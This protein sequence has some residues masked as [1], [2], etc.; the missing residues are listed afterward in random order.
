[1]VSG[2][3]FDAGEKDTPVAGAMMSLSAESGG[4]F[5]QIRSG[6]HG[7]PP[8][9]DG[10]PAPVGGQEAVEPAE[11]DRA[12]GDPGQWSARGQGPGQ[13][14]LVLAAEPLCRVGNES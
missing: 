8:S 3:V 4:R 7:G 1:M 9:R 14:P 12:D 10:V 13:P 6:E 11:A 5:G 2:M